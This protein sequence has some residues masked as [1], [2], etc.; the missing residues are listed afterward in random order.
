ME[1]STLSDRDVVAGHKPVVLVVDDNESVRSVLNVALQR[2]GFDVW[3]ASTGEEALDIFR[4]QQGI[5][6]VLMDVRMPGL[7]GP[8][9]L[10]AL[11]LL[12]PDIPCCF[13]TG[14]S[15]CY[16]HEELRRRGAACVFAKPFSLAEISQCLWSL[17]DPI[18]GKAA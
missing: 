15:G 1:L 7:D 12:N 11:R 18:G 13:M 10:E 16:R 3:L 5:D 4:H 14:D 8:E 17:L 2:Q 9:T 6:L